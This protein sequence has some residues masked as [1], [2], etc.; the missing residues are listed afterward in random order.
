MFMSNR[1][2]AVRLPKAMALPEGVRQVEITKIGNSRIIS[3]A[4]ESWDV[5]FAGPPVSDD[6][7]V[8]REQPESQEREPF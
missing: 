5:F 3:P 1:S 2:Q 6:F 8:T 4:G 7:M